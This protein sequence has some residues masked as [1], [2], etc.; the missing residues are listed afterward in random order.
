MRLLMRRRVIVVL[1]VSVLAAGTAL[2]WVGGSEGTSEDLGAACRAD[3]TRPPCGLLEPLAELERYWR[4]TPPPSITVIS[5][6][7]STPCGKGSAEEGSFYCPEDQH[8]YLQQEDLDP[9]DQSPAVA[10]AS[11]IYL[12]AHEYG[13][14][15]QDARGLDTG[16]E[17]LGPAGVS[18]RYELQADCLA[19]V[20]LRS[21]RA[22]PRSAYVAAVRL[23]GDDVGED[24]LPA[25]EYAHGTGQQ[26]VRWFLK[27]LDTGREGACATGDVRVL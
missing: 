14:A 8:V 12:L 26:R 17:G 22:T 9:S 1:A 6:D 7:T 16:Q 23:G 5:G 20:W 21:R 10:K 3:G 18:V 2:W 25:A 24:P 19:G 11:A 13:H 27:G 4:L 15:V